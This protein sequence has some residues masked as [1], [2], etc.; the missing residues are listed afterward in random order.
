MSRIN[1]I[2]ELARMGYRPGEIAKE[3]GADIKTVKKYLGADDFSPQLPFKQDK[4][5]K[6]DPYRETVDKWLEEDKQN[7]YKQKHTAKRILDRLREEFPDFE[8][9]YSMVQRYVK[10]TRAA[11]VNKAN[12][13]L[14]W[15]PG[16]AQVDFGEAD[17]IDGGVKNRKKF[18]TVSFPYS[19]N[20]YSQVF[21]GETAECVCQGLK[22]IFTYIGKVPKLLVFDNATGVGRRVGNQIRETELFLRFRNHYGVPIRFCNPDAGYEKGNVERKVGYNRSNLFVPVPVFNDLIQYNKDLL[23]S[24]QKKAGEAHYK[25][26]ELIGTLFLEDAAAMNPLPE[27]PFDVCRYV[28]MKADGYGKVCLNGRH[29]YSTSPELSK[30]EVM[31][32]I[33]AHHVDVYRKDGKLLVSHSR[34]YGERRTDTT[35]HSTSLAV[36]LRNTGAWHNSGVREYMPEGLRTMLDEQSRSE[37]KEHLKLL[38]NLSRDY[39]FDNAL[40]AMEEAVKRGRLNLCDTAVLA[41]RMAGYGLETPPDT[42]PDLRVYDETFLVRREVQPS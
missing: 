8:G 9:S 35:D 1:N 40:A 14:V 32:G 36:L 18:L 42:G 31:L 13:E 10:T 38:Q 37:L 3:T 28:W 26:L 23:D 29:Y 30:H 41:A 16:E 12:Q 6:L 15:H 20:G 24:H 17:F 22:D 34:Q 39:G 7:W 33:R 27:K 4:P 21:G 19:N 5:S 25:K 11:A 2:K